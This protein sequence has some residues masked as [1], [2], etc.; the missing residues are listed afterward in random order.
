VA[1]ALEIGF[2]FALSTITIRAA[3]SIGGAGV[4]RSVRATVGPRVL[5]GTGLGSAW[6]IAGGVV[7]AL[8]ARPRHEGPGR[9]AA[10]A[11][12]SDATG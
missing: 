1:F 11:P 2:V 4:A 12:V 5:V 8:L 9:D 10:T 7:G 3:G 6:G